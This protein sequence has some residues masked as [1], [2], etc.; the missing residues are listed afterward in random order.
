MSIWSRTSGCSTLQ[1]ATEGISG[2]ERRVKGNRR[3][4]LVLDER[5]TT[6]CLADRKLEG[7]VEREEKDGKYQDSALHCSRLEWHGGMLLAVRKAAFDILK[8]YR[9]MLVC[10][11]PLGDPVERHWNGHSRA[12]KFR[13][14]PMHRGCAHTVESRVS[15]PSRKP[16]RNARMTA[17]LLR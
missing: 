16:L 11:R 14:I 7:S 15:A 8:S 5:R 17:V 1:S 9:F 3:T 10:S 4:I 13:Y 6:N 12:P 2:F